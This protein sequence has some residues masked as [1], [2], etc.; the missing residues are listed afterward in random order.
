M[1]RRKNKNKNKSLVLVA[2][3]FLVGSG[4]VFTANNS[5]LRGFQA[6]KVQ[7]KIEKLSE[8]N[9]ELELQATNLRSLQ[10]LTSSVHAAGNMVKVEK[11]R[12]IIPAKRASETQ[13]SALTNKP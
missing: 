9:R 13:A 12:H 8:E 3:F 1:P 2:V 6:R 5:V 10:T 7:Q 4:L 11:L